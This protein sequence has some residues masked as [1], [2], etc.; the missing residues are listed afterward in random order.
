MNI[1]IFGAGEIGSHLATILSSEQHNVTLIDQNEKALENI[2]SESDV[3]TIGGFDEKGPILSSLLDSSPDIFIAITGND[4]INLVACSI[5][6]NLGYPITVAKIKRIDFLFHSKIDFGRLFFV[7][8]F[9]SP[10]MLTA[11]DILKSLINPGDLAIET[12]AHGVIQ[13]RTITLPEG[14]KHFNKPIAQLNLPHELIISLIRRKNE[15]HEDVIIFPHGDDVLLPEDEV[16][17]IGE[18]ALM[19]DLN[20]IFEFPEK[21][22]RSVAIIGASEVG[23]R[24]ATILEKLSIHVKFIEKDEAKCNKLAETLPKSTIINR[25]GANLRFLETEQLQLADA[26]IACTSKDEKN[27]LLSMLAKQIGCK[28]IFSIISDITLRPVL[29]KLNIQ[30]SISPKVNV[31]KRIMSIMHTETISS[32]AS[33][34]D[35]K[36]NVLEIK[37]SPDSG[38]I[39]IPLADLSHRLP[40]DFLIA[41]I[42]NRGRVMIGK[43]NRI[44]SPH[45]TIIAVTSPKH[46]KEIQDLF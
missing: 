28:N 14:W 8:H 39:G 4:D 27:L 17:L 16:T 38:L 45:D 13:M 1:V 46:M 22:I 20:T 18:T 7:D 30:Y 11:H 41:A 5:A 40:E 10:E 36:A 33:L 44:I 24:L 3:A 29:N 26:I 34:Y 15:K 12:F 23:I 6:K 35:N 21:K 37:V 43:G 31:V 19:H 25:D 2:G 42:E 9:L 32:I